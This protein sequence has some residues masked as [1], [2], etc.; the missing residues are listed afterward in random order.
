MNHNYEKYIYVTTVIYTFIVF[1]PYTR[2]NIC[3]S[4]QSP[5]SRNQTWKR[6]KEKPVISLGT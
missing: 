1:I 2:A 3:F 6:Y 4:Y 5:G